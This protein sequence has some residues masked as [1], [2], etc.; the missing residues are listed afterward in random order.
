MKLGASS[1]TVIVIKLMLTGQSSQVYQYINRI[2]RLGRGMI[3]AIA[4]MQ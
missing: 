2:V 1:G 4:V 3:C